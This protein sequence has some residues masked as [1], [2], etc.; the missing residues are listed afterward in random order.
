MKNQETKKNLATLTT[1]RKMTI[2]AM[3]MAIFCV[4]M[5]ITQNF[6]FGAYQI[7][8]ATSLYALGYIFPFL[9]IPMGLAN[10]LSNLL[11]GSFGLYD[12]LG[13]AIAGF[14]TTGCAVLVAK[15]HWKYKKLLLFLPVTFIPG[16]MVPLWL[17]PALGMPYWALALSLCIGQAFCGVFGVI[18]TIILSRILKIER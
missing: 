1:V 18:L 5:Y 11:M 14:L 2:S 10:A 6:A 7:R 15:V 13:G 8:I 9:C 12:I 16:L 3:C 4:I 17:A